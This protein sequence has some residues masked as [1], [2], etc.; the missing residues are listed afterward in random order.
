MRLLDSGTCLLE[1]KEEIVIIPK[2]LHHRF[3]FNGEQLY[4]HRILHWMC[5]VHSRLYE[6]TLQ[7]QVVVP[8]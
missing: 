7:V 6:L 5:C 4:S 8:P 2:S 3:L 1:E